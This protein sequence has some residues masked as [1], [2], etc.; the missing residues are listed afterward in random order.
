VPGIHDDRH[1]IH[2]AIAVP[3]RPV[4]DVSSTTSGAAKD[5]A[6]GNEAPVVAGS[7]VDRMVRPSPRETSVIFH[8]RLL[9]TLRGGSRHTDDPGRTVEPRSRNVTE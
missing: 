9:A 5:W 6:W 2:V 7:S 1:F 8:F 4:A 3:A